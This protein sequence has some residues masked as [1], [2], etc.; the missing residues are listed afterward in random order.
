M[1]IFNSLFLDYV[2]CQ[3]RANNHDLHWNRK[4][5]ISF[6][7][8]APTHHACISKREHGPPVPAQQKRSNK[9]FTEGCLQLVLFALIAQ[10]TLTRDKSG[11]ISGFHSE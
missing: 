5:F 3:G 1:L 6:K 8:L 9:Q 7:S 2:K 4:I 10:C 11:Q